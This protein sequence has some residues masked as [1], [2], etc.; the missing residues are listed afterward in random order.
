MTDGAGR[1][2]SAGEIKARTELVLAD[3]FARIRTVEEALT[4]LAPRL[5]A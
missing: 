4:A 5:A 3:R 1:T 2:W